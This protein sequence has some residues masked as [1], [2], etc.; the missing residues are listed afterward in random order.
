MCIF[1]VYQHTFASNLTCLHLFR[2]WFFI[3]NSL[4]NYRFYIIEEVINHFF[5]AMWS[6]CLRFENYMLH[7]WHATISAFWFYIHLKWSDL[8]VSGH[9]LRIL[10]DDYK[11]LKFHI[12]TSN[13]INY[14]IEKTK[15]LNQIRRSIGYIFI[16]G[17]K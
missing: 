1:T 14:C 5:K 2:I 12:R 9:L 6:A 4:R 7:I 3:L 11:S 10:F 15:R 13:Q 16:M 8:S 17:M